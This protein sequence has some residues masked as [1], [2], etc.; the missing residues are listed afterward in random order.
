MFRLKGY[1]VALDDAFNKLSPNTKYN[2]M[3]AFRAAGEECDNLQRECI[4]TVYP[5]GFPLPPLTNPT[6]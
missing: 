5:S 4:Q 3:E 6:L 1:D 2:L